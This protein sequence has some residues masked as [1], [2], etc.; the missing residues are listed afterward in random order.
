MEE[1]FTRIEKKIVAKRASS[2]HI[3]FIHLFFIENLI[4]ITKNVFRTLSVV[5]YSAVI[6]LK[7]QAW[8]A[9]ECFACKKKHV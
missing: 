6:F 3:L 7:K 8:C 5:E 9:S 4:A 1:F 2:L